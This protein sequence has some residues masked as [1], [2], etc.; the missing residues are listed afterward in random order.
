MGKNNI[1]LV[2]DEPVTAMAEKDQLEKYDFEVEVVYNSE[3]C[4]EYLDENKS[5]DLI[6]M[7][8]ELEGKRDGIETA[9]IIQKQEDLPILYLTSH[10]DPEYLNRIQD[11]VS[12][13]FLSKENCSGL[14]LRNAIHQA[15]R[16]YRSK[17]K[18]KEQNKYLK[19]KEE[20][21]KKIFNASE[22]AMVMIRDSKL[23][24]VN[25]AFTN[26][27]GYNRE[28]VLGKPID[29][30]PIFTNLEKNLTDIQLDQDKEIE[31]ESEIRTYGDSVRYVKFQLVEIDMDFESAYILILRDFTEQVELIQKLERIKEPEEDT[32]GMVTICSRC[33]R[34]R[35]D[36]QEENW[37]EP[38]EYVNKYLAD[39]QFSHGI[40][41]ECI[42]E[43][44]PDFY[45]RKLK[46]ME[47]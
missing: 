28:N 22:D 34:I 29:Q 10:Q 39:I 8:I 12:Y 1:L 32:E 25:Q 7:D 2:E 23:Y 26:L 45:K 46:D 38:E 15:L 6:L 42:K 4:L 27:T 3:E 31:F 20:E 37:T 18:I 11:T 33:K 44:Y 9:K 43:L 40:C 16:L 47:E 13:N 41:P 17:Q 35:D 5:I 24:L 30:I 19:R 36:K 14:M 21:Y